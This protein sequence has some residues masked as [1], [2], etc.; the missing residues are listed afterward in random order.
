MVQDPFWTSIALN[1]KKYI[2]LIKRKRKK[3]KKID[4]WGA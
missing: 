3:K 4:D 1:G 2:K